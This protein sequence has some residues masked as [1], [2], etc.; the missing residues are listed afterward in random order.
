MNINIVIF[1]LIIAIVIITVTIVTLCL[2][3]KD[4]SFCGSDFSK[5]RNIV[6]PVSFFDNKT[7]KCGNDTYGLRKTLDPNDAGHYLYNIDPPAGK[8][9]NVYDCDGKADKGM[10]HISMNCLPVSEEGSDH[11]K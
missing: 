7:M 1:C 8:T 6:L 10:N 9:T 3:T 11:R 4:N 2:I 5:E